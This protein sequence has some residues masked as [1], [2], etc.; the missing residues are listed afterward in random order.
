[1]I[2]IFHGKLT[3]YYKRKLW[4]HLAEQIKTTNK[5]NLK[6]IRI[7]YNFAFVAHQDDRRKGGNQDPYITHPVEVAII[8]SKEMGFGTTTIIASLLHDVVEDTE[9]NLKYIENRFGSQVAAIVDAV[10]KITNISGGESSQQMDTF[11]NMIMTIPNDYR[12]FIVKIADR[13]HNM[14]TMDDMPDNTRIIKASENLYLYAKIAEIAGLWKIKNETETLSFKYLLSED[15][16]KIL[17]KQKKY[18][19]DVKKNIYDFQKKLRI[20][21]E[22]SEYKFEIETIERSLYSVFMKMKKKNLHYQDVY[23]HFST[24]IIIDTPEVN[25]RFVYPIYWFITDYFKEKDGSLRDWII[26][27]KKN[28][29]RALIFDVMFEGQW[30]EIQILSKDDNKIAKEGFLKKEK[31]I[32]PGFINLKNVIQNDLNLDDNKFEIIDRFRELLNTE[33]IFIFS[34]IGEVFELP[35]N[36]TVLDFAFY[37]HSDIGEKCL[38]AKINDNQS[39]R[40]PSYVLKSTQKVEILT[41]NKTALNQN[42]L[43]FVTT[44]KAKKTIKHLLRKNNED[45]NKEL[46]IKKHD[47]SYRKHF[48]IDDDIDYYSADC[49]K[50]IV[51]EKAMAYLTKDNKI[52]VHQEKCHKSLELRAKYSK[53]TTVVLWKRINKKDA[54]QTALEFEGEDR[55]GILRDI[56]SIIS[57]ELSVNMKKLTVENFDGI[58]KGNVELYIGSLELLNEIIEKISKLDSIRNIKRVDNIS[59]TDE[60]LDL[61]FL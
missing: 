3:D 8:A 25:R 31:D 61:L 39:V 45:K 35:K 40:S 43:N 16:N 47:F 50:P 17:E 14:R 44:N 58:F 11:V 4:Q 12:V 18:D 48:V 34:P 26:K 30:Q 6:R 2:P 59:I 41:S 10:T 29:F 28:G 36:Y 1:M 51:G 55:V 56:L 5:N 20:Y 13:L 42:M 38:G 57:S 46:I 9:Y 32:T 7:A 19:V 23:N 27:P 24:R 53:N 33:T 52:E 37:I 15:Y 21:F 54:I 49:C 60:N 22:K